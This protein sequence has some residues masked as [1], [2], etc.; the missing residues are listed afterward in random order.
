M[1]SLKNLDWQARPQDLLGQ[2][3]S[4]VQNAATVD[5]SRLATKLMGDAVATNV[6]MLGFGGEGS[7]LFVSIV[8][9]GLLDRSWSDSATSLNFVSG[10]QSGLL[11]S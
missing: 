4:G 10:S 2:L 11:P 8:R 7:E 3:K 6:F 1:A 9:V 5:A